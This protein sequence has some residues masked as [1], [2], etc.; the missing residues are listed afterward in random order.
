V[1]I[2]DIAGLHKVIGLWLIKLPEPP[3]GA[4]LRFLRLEMEITQ[5]HLAAGAS[6]CRSEPR[7]SVAARHPS[8]SAV[9]R[10]AC[11]AARSLARTTSS[12]AKRVASSR[13]TVRTPLLSIRLSSRA[14]AS[15]SSIGVGAAYRL[16]V[17]DLETSS[18]GEGLVAPTFLPVCLHGNDHWEN[19]PR[20]PRPACADGKFA[21]RDFSLQT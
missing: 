4:E 13:M 19:M 18:V 1:S 3:N 2:T 17:G 16:G 8:P 5:G 14:N 7:R 21:G 6:D 20:C 12:R 9:E 10:R 15:L 11:Q